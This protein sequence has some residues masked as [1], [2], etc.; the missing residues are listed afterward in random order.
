VPSLPNPSLQGPSQTPLR[1]PA[2]TDAAAAVA[3][4][5][6]SSSKQL[7]ALASV[8]SAVVLVSLKIF[9][10][11]STGSLGVLSEALHS[12]LDLVAAI[13]TYLSVRVSDLPAD[14]SHTYGHGKVESFSAFVETGLLFLT[15]VYIV[16][17][18]LQRL[19]FREVQIR[20]S[21][22]AIGILGIALG[23]DLL[24]SRALARVARETS[25]EALEADALHFATDVWSTA[26][27]I[28][29]IGVV[30][31]GARTGLT[32]LRFADPLAALIVSAVIIWVG[33][34]LARRT[35]DAL[36]DAAPKGL[37]E[38]VT[39]AVRELD[40]VLS[41]E[42]VRVR[43]A[44]NKH[45]VD[46]TISVPRSASF[47]QVH[48]ISDTVERRVEE[49][50]PSDVMV[51]ME[52]RAQAGEHL[53]DA[54]RAAAQRQG[55]AI[56]ELSAH[57]LDGRLFIEL[58]LE[59]DEQLSLKDAHGLATRLEDEIRTLPSLGNEAGPADVVV[60]IH[61]EPLG[62]HIASVDRSST[63]MHQLA[64]SVEEFINGLAPQFAALSDCHEVNVREVEHK[65]LVSCHCTMEGSLPITDIHDV[66]ALLEDRVREKFP[67]IA[68]VTI[69]PEPR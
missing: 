35:M 69:H 40:G 31:L 33:A 20:P 4:S 19:F 3:S 51:H 14:E 24:R 37:Q 52:P 43:R 34:R 49:I 1:T 60:N 44:G 21:A 11:T 63:E 68:R 28:L 62:T 9:L 54:I 23:I 22:L 38:Q 41:A 27:V 12:S 7:A 32:W 47:E 53:F 36:L 30:W 50:V 2:R 57:P 8:G 15:A 61:I 67:Q 64:S 48:A 16:W 6:S 18:A 26:V 58:H 39:Q 17:E 65:I 13:L 29:G 59:V 66:T 46:V 55:L 5:K 10:T 42:R 45:F 56:H 25:S